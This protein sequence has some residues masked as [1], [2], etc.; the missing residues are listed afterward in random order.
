V[1]KNETT[2]DE[3]KTDYDTGEDMKPDDNHHVIARSASQ[4]KKRM[5][6]ET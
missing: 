5:N 2:S 4:V 3:M 6:D 1:S